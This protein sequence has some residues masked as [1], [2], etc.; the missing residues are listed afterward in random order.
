[1]LRA[2]LKS[3]QQT[4]DPANRER[5]INLIAKDFN[6]DSKTAARSLDETIKALSDTGAMPDDAVK[7]EV[8]ELQ[9]RLKSKTQVPVIRIVDYTLLKEALAE[10]KR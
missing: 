10:M 4:K 8:E 3:V 1:M 9:K 7:S 2:T 5:V 6:M